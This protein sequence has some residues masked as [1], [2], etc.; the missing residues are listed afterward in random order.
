MKNVIVFWNMVPE[1]VEMYSLEVN[2]KEFEIL[3]K[4]NGKMINIDEMTYELDYLNYAVMRK[5]WVTEDTIKDAV[6]LGV[7]A[8]VVAKWAD[9]RV[10]CE[11]ENAPYVPNFKIDAIIVTG[12]YL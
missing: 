10:E 5:E 3:K 11:E 6:S 8:D 4:C 9:R 2:D 7:D 12:F 1:S